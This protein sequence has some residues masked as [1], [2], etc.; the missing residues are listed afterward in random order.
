MNHT[1]HVH[2][3]TCNSKVKKFTTLVKTRVFCF[4]SHVRTERQWNKG[5]LYFPIIWRQWLWRWWPSMVGIPGPNRTKSKNPRLRGL[6]ERSTYDSSHESGEKTFSGDTWASKSS[7]EQVTVK[8]LYSTARGVHT[9][10]PH[11]KSLGNQLLPGLWGQAIWL[12]ILQ[13]GWNS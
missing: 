3:Y 8:A 4:F 11:F 6:V 2:V 5:Q 9:N 10:P 1:I 7:S 13:K 12:P